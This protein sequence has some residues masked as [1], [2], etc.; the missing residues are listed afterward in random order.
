M[1]V[2]TALKS[3]IKK[4]PIINELI[5]DR[6]KLR[7]ECNALISERKQLRRD[8]GFVNPGHF[9]SPIPS[10]E[11]IKKD[12]SIIFGTMP[13]VIQGLELH[14]SEQLHLLEGFVQYYKE[15][16]FRSHKTQGM[17]YYF[18]NPAYSYS[19]AIFLYCIIRHLK[20]KRIIEI[21]SGF[22]S[23]VTLDTNELLFN[24][25]IETT[26]IEPF[27]ELLLSIMKEKDK[28]KAR[29]ISKRLQDVPLSEFETLSANDI[30]FIDS[31]HVSKINSDVNRIFFDILPSLAPG[32]HIHF[33]N[34]FFP[35]EYPKEWIYEGRAWNEMYMLRTFLQY[36]TTFRVVLMNTFMEYFYEPFFR[37]KMPLCLKN[38]GG[39]IW[40]RK[41]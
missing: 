37:E 41:E 25:S 29:V 39:S 16:P 13:R 34:I 6:E 5:S 17:R 38:T 12:E 23:C 15:Q 27:P 2:F 3:A 24:D 7:N 4:L 28:N 26:F 36:N 40:I 14:E 18:E 9:Y 31:T 30:L 11:E 1:F 22:S 10:L 8:C 35:F 20:P 19:D 32:V 21:G 33:H